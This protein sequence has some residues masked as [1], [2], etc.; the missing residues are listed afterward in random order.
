[1]CPNSVGW[2]VNHL[3]QCD[4]TPHSMIGCMRGNNVHPDQMRFL[5]TDLDP[6]CFFM[7]NYPS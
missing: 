5:A 1:M 2:V 7:P 4:R 3:Y 6:H